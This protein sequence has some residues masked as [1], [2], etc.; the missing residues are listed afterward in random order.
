MF[1]Y[2]QQQQQHI[3]IVLILICYNTNTII[4]FNMFCTQ[5]LSFFINSFHPICLTL[6]LV[7]PHTTHSMWQGTMSWFGKMMFDVSCH[8]L[9]VVRRETRQRVRQSGWKELIK[10]YICCAKHIKTNSGS[11]IGTYRNN[12]NENILFLSGSETNQINYNNNVLLV[13]CYQIIWK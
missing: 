1:R 4:L 2:Q 12:N 10:N 7:S 11:G 13:F 8:M 6:C 3:I 9:C 5:K